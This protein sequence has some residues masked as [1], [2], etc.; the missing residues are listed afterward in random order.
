MSR[1]CDCFLVHHCTEPKGSNTPLTWQGFLVFV[2]FPVILAGG[3][4][5]LIAAIS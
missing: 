2:G 1:E 4:F 5:W 3:F